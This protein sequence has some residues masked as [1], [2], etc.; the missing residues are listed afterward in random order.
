MQLF[1]NKGTTN[2]ISPSDR[3]KGLSTIGVWD[4]VGVFIQSFKTTVM[5]GSPYL[6]FLNTFSEWDWM[7]KYT[8]RCNVQQQGGKLPLLEINTQPHIN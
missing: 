7:I 1:T 4:G 3:L 5:G 6:K 8:V 2:K